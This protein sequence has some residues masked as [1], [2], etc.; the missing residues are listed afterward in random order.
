MDFKVSENATYEDNLI[1]D[2]PNTFNRMFNQMNL[3]INKIAIKYADP[4]FIEGNGQVHNVKNKEQLSFR[5]NIPYEKFQEYGK[6]YVD[7]KI[8]DSKNYN[9][10]EGSTIITLNEDYVSSL[11]KGDHNIKVEMIDGEITAKFSVVDKVEI[12]TPIVD[13]VNRMI[14]NPETGDNL[15]LITIL[16]LM[17]SSFGIIVFKKKRI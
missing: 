14:E 6:V 8:V 12:I 17:L 11:G 2:V 7:D 15:I 3:N 5:L 10:T 9:V 4:V 13:A 16:L 1:V